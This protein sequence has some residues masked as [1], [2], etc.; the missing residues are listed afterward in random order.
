MPEQFFGLPHDRGKGEAALMRA[1]FEDAFK[2]F[3]KQFI[4]LGLIKAYGGRQGK[5][6]RG[7]LPRTSTGRSPLSMSVQS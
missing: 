1:V 2:C 5:P 4:S 3:V 6:R 7:S